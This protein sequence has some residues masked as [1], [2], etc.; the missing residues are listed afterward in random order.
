MSARNPHSTRLVAI[1][2]VAA[3]SLKHTVQPQFSQTGSIGITFFFLE[4][5][6][7]T[8]FSL[9]SQDKCIL[10]FCEYISLTFKQNLPERRDPNVKR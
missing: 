6:S 7:F 1:L 8:T 3:T 9:H 4:M 5:Q 10:I 2:T